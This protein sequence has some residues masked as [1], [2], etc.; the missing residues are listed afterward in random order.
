DTDMAIPLLKTF[1]QGAMGAYPES[2]YFKMPDWQ[3]ID[4]IP[5]TL[6]LAKARAWKELGVSILGGC[7]GIGP[8]HIK[9]LS[10]EFAR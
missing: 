1:W 2:G 4:V 3:F 5:P 9:A 7:C 8:E 10:K 6:L